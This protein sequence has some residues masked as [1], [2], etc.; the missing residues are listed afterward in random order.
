MLIRTCRYILILTGRIIVSLNDSFHEPLP[1]PQPL[2][3]ASAWVKRA[4]FMEKRTPL[5]FH[6]VS[7]FSADQKGKSSHSPFTLNIFS[8][9]INRFFCSSAFIGSFWSKKLLLSPQTYSVSIALMVFLFFPKVPSRVTY[10]LVVSVHFTW[11]QQQKLTLV[12][13]CTSTGG[14]GGRTLHESKKKQDEI[15]NEI[16]WI[17]KSWKE[18][19][20]LSHN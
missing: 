1:L 18:E 12:F 15:R 14:G 8:F 20:T 2:V 17:S 5:I 9:V 4:A 16:R 19:G 10:F 13:K 11:R 6:L 3:S 7:V